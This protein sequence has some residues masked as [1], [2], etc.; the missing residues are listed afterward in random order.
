MLTIMQTNAD[1]DE[2]SG[3]IKYFSPRG[4]YV[5]T[6]CFSVPPFDSLHRHLRFSSRDQ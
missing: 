5:G 6:M 1:D 4:L 3:C 2:G